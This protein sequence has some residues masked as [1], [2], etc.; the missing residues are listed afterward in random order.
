MPHI[1]IARTT[2]G[3]VTAEPHFPGVGVKSHGIEQGMKG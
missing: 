3:E 1:V 2:L